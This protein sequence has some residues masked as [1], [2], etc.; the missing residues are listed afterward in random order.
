MMPDTSFA[1]QKTGLNSTVNFQPATLIP[2]ATLETWRGRAYK[3]AMLKLANLLELRP[4][5]E[6]AKAEGH[7]VLMQMYAEA[8]D[9]FMVHPD[10]VRA[11]LA[12][13]R[14]YSPEKLAYWI[15]NG[16]SFAHIEMANVLAE[17]A[18]KTPM[19]LLDEAVTLGDENGKPMT[20]NKLI[21]FAKGEQAGSSDIVRVNFL[22]GRLGKFPN[23][24]KWADEK[25]ARFN[26]WLDQGRKEFF[27]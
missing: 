22:L 21:A 19:Q 8:A 4:M 15:T 5:I 10:T 17:G 18:N 23:I 25:T 3:S 9:A 13:I 11:D 16:V 14:R 6:D 1:T 24:L 26:V 2:A 7:R 27:S 12:T 20:V